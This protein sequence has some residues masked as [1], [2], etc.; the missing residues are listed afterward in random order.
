MPSEMLSCLSGKKGLGFLSFLWGA[1]TERRVYVCGGG[2]RG[3]GDSPLFTS[4]G[5]STH[6]GGGK[7]LCPSPIA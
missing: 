2:C 4:L 3:H 7:G 1:L 6:V 5:L